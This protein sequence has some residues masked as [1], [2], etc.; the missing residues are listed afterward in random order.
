MSWIYLTPFFNRNP[1]FSCGDFTGPRMVTA[2][3][4]SLDVSLVLSRFVCL[5]VKEDNLMLFVMCR[6]GVGSKAW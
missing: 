1:K 4:M 6:V 2:E 5:S 3:Y